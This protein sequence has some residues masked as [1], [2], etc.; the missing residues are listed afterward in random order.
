[1]EKA[2]AAIVQNPGDSM[3]RTGLYIAQYHHSKYVRQDNSPRYAKYLGY[4]DA[5]E[6]YPDLKPTTFRDFFEEVLAGKGRKVYG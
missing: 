6:L 5:R 3:K 1:V 2:K 4:I